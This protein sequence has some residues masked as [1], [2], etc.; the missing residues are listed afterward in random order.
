MSIRII[1]GDCLT[2]LPQLAA[3]GVRAH[4]VVCDPPYGLGFM[5]KDWD[6]PDNVAFRPETW[7]AVMACMRPGAHLVAFGGTRTWHRMAVAIEDAGFEIRDSLAWLYGCGF[8]KSHDVSKGIDKAGGMSPAQQGAL[9]KSRREAVGMSREDVAGVV[10]CAAT[11]LRN[12]EEGRQRSAGRAVEHITPSPE[13]RAKLVDLLGYSQ[14]E[15]RAAG[16]TTDR[17]DDGTVYAVGHTGA[18]T[19]GGHTSEAAAWAGWGTALKPAF[20]PIILARVPLDG[21]VAGNTLRHGCGGLNI[22]ACRIPARDG[23]NE[24]CVTQ[25]VNTARTSF[26]PAVSQRTFAPSA[27]GRWPANVIHDGSAEVEA[28]FAVYGERPTGNLNRVAGSGDGY[29]FGGRTNIGHIASTGSASRFFYSAKA[30][31]AD[32]AGSKHP[33]VKPTDLMRWLVQL[34]CPPGGLVLDPFAGTGSTGLAADQLGIDA[35]LVE[36]DPTYAADAL[37]KI[38]ADGG[39]FSTAAAE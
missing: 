16:V 31:A 36:R 30:D 15:R 20:E 3:E 32:R 28:A 22:D 19:S 37:R 13:F 29:G 7:A 33:T 2:V 39:L 23:Y 34:T 10:G 38:S 18:L 24:N 11:S 1:T 8:P 12:W 9:L 14:D 26:A 35:I 27:E 4:A 17:R 21:T 25:G 6:A 5:G